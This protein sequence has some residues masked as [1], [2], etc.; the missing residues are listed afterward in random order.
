MSKEWHKG[1][2]MGFYPSSPYI[3]PV[4]S[5]GVLVIVPC[6]G[7][8]SFNHHRH[9]NWAD[10]KQHQQKRLFS[11]I[12][13]WFDHPVTLRWPCHDLGLIPMW[14]QTSTRVT[15]CTWVRVHEMYL[16]YLPLVQTWQSFCHLV[17]SCHT[18]KWWHKGDLMGF[19]PSSPYITHCNLSGCC[20]IAP[21]WG[22]GDFQSP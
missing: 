21:F 22:L 13:S 10:L 11:P 17:H 12:W 9:L 4:T 7:Q 8:V 16:K 15:R 19:Y 14:R 6:W 20:G 18:T 5:W 1:D 3:T 2:L